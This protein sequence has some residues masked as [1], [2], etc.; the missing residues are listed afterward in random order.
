MGK[1]CGYCGAPVR[2]L[3]PPRVNREYY[4]CDTCYQVFTINVSAWNFKVRPV[5]QEFS[6]AEMSEILSGN[7][8]EVL[9]NHKKA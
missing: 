6:V 1:V 4:L 9:Q 2:G 7:G 5:P 8:I 3:L